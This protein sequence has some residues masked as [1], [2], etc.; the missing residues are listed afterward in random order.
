MRKNIKQ[1]EKCIK[2][3]SLF[4]VATITV[5]FTNLEL[6]STADFGVNVWSLFWGSWLKA[7]NQNKFQFVEEVLSKTQ[8]KI[9]EIKSRYLQLF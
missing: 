2:A 4:L 7:A 1:N 3:T 5:T 9:I 6:S 8:K